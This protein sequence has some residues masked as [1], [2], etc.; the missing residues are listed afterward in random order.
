MKK[1]KINKAYRNFRDGARA[2]M[3][4]LRNEG[5]ETVHAAKLLLKLG[6][7]RKLEKN[8]MA[9]L[10]AQSAD[11]AK[12]IALFGLFIIPGGSLITPLA[13]EG[14][15]KLGIDPYP[16][17]QSHLREV[18][19]IRKKI[20]RIL[21]EQVLGEQEIRM[22]FDLP[23]P[24]DIWGLK[25]H[26]D[27][28]GKKLFVV[29][30]A[31]RDVLTGKK[32]KDYDLAT[33]A[34][35]EEMMSFLPQATKEEVARN[36]GVAPQ[37]KYLIIEA[38]NIF[39]VVHLVTSEKGRYEIAT[40]RIDAG[41]DHRKPETQFST[42][43]QDVKRRDLTMNALFYDLD[44]KE[45]V[46]LVG[47]IADIQ[48][49]RVRTVGDPTQ[50]FAEN[51]IRKL[52]ALRFTARIGS[53]LDQSIQDSLR[54]N[55]SLD[56]EAPEAIMAEVL[57][58]IEQAKSVKHF[59]SMLFEFGFDKW[60]FKGMRTNPDGIVEEK[61][62]TLLYAS[63]L[64]DENPNSI[65]GGMKTG[66]KYAD[67]F[68]KRVMFFIKFRDFIPERI[69]EFYK[70]NQATAHISHEDLLRAGDVL[71]YDKKMVD[72]FF[73]FSP[74]ANAEKLMAQGF[75]KAALGKAMKQVEIDHFLNLL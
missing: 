30:G 26:F 20:R 13:A 70:L 34:T 47:G 37:G 62:P 54:A 68:A 8:E 17:D 18:E 5:P 32:I 23:I 63:I 42:I 55:P 44:T 25:Q 53:E 16:S 4:V 24:Q 45:I 22:A 72:A 28:A 9:F 33:D 59:M 46:D 14:L 7:G 49:G 57:K 19:M 67:S 10:K 38:G 31:V 65:R 29:G 6:T 1:A 12:M 52:R 36:N 39:P 60:V 64:R 35:P 40:F 66:M 3:T 69:M 27:A 75:K 51:Q 41:T 48:A 73:K 58:G 71:G 15:R 21:A 11:V 61:D 2:A 43:D 56:E 50:R 74:I